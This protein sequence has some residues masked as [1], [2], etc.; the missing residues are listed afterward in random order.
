MTTAEIESQIGMAERS[1]DCAK[2][3]V[4]EL[5]IALRGAE[6]S[7]ERS[8]VE[9]QRERIRREINRIERGLA[10]ARR[11]VATARELLETSWSLRGD[12]PQAVGVPQLPSEG[13]HES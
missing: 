9:Y 3:R 4:D 1:F 8:M 13:T 12:V 6:N 11:D 10:S 2:N 5:E 7:L